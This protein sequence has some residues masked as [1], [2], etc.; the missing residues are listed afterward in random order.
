MGGE[1]W[2]GIRGGV[3]IH[4]QANTIIVPHTHTHTRQEP[5]DNVRWG[6]AAIGHVKDKSEGMSLLVLKRPHPNANQ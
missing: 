1:Q 6:W 5:T 3:N 4:I 2:A